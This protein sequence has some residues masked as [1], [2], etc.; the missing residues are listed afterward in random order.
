VKNI[1]SEFFKFLG[2][3]AWKYKFG[4]IVFIV[5][6]VVIT[7]GYV[8][9]WG[10]TG[11]TGTTQ[12]QTTNKGEV[13]TTL[14]VP[15]TLWNWIQVLIIPGVLAYAA[16]WLN[17]RQSSTERRTTLDNQ[18]A[19]VLDSYLDGM[20]DLLL[21]KKLR[22]SKS[23][24][25]EVRQVARAKTLTALRR[26]DPERKGELLRFL[27][28]AG[29]IKKGTHIISL[30][31]A[32]LGGAILAGAN[33]RWADLTGANLTEAQIYWAHLR[34][35]DLTG[36]NLIEAN[37]TV[38]DLTGAHLREADLTGANLTGAHLRGAHLREA[39]LTGANLSEADL[40]EADLREADLTGANLRGATVTEEQLAQ[41][42]SL[43]D[44]T[45]P[46]GRKRP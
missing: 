5:A 41:A 32:Y 36:A 43:Q 31:G 42:K 27:Y 6:A 33:L 26:L 29:L 35:A 21:N 30:S 7:L 23:D 28:E 34:E 10:W 8:H 25:E 18:Q 12:I 17:Q 4:L 38:T 24:D 44:A 20:S 3:K 46:D 19:A 2:R 22:E 16:Y 39:D 14:P 9:M 45:M 1:L 11:L 40:S 37:L 13:T 15:I